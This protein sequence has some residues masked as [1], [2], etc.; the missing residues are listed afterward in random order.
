MENGFC[1]SEVIYLDSALA[2]IAV[3][4]CKDCFQ[5]EHWGKQSLPVSVEGA[6]SINN[7]VHEQSK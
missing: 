1:P 4:V 7:S 5:R 6:I 2:S 3:E